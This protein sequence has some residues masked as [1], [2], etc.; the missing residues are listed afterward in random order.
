[1][2]REYIRQVIT[3][4]VDEQDLAAS[5]KDYLGGKKVIIY[6]SFLFRTGLTR[7]SGRLSDIPQH[8][9]TSRLEEL[10]ERDVIKGYLQVGPPPTTVGTMNQIDTGEC[11][12]SWMVY[13]SAGPGMGKYVY[14][15]GYALSPSGLLIPDRETVSP[16]AREGWKKQAAKRG[17][18]PLD[19]ITLPVHSR[20]TPNDPH[21][22]CSP[23][24]E[25]ALN[26]AYEGGPDDE[27]LLR[28]LTAEHGRMM[29]ALGPA[30]EQVE[31]W[32]D[33]QGS[34]FFW[35]NMFL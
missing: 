22:D 27:R 15:L 29:S 34:K 30:E 7:G 8:E 25:D 3:E 11:Y 14:G 10:A 35:G 12:G 4:S 2:L 1:M 21:D 9:M 17:K 13:K 16:T 31:Y 24:D 32:L 26:Y 23:Q 19:D 18:K 20:R 28:L 5:V 6:D 33:S